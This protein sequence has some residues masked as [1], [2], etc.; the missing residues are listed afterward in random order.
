MPRFKQ[1]TNEVRW[2]Y[3]PAPREPA[4]GLQRTKVEQSGYRV[5]EVEFK[6]AKDG[7]GIWPKEVMRVLVGGCM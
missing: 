7:L 4:H 2:A 3:R 5:E 6:C 1:L